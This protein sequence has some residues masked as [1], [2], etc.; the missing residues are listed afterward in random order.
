[1]LIHNE[2]YQFVD[3]SITVYDTSTLF[4]DEKT[5]TELLIET[6]KVE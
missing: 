6:L 2:Y 1:M 5:T 4:T 3:R